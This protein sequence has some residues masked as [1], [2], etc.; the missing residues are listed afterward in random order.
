MKNGDYKYDFSGLIGFAI[1]G[2]VSSIF[3]V[4]LLISWLINHVKII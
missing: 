3:G 2:L 4:S 1:I